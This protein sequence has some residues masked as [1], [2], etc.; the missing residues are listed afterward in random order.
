MINLI[1]FLISFQHLVTFYRVTLRAS[2]NR[3]SSHTFCEVHRNEY[4][5]DDD[6]E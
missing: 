5:S 3:P 2:S 1:A 6:V 4:R